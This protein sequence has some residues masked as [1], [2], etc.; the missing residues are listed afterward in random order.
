MKK[1]DKLKIS[2]MTCAS[3]SS[4]IERKLN[5]IDSVMEANVNLAMESANIYYDENKININDLISEIEK[6]GFQ[7]EKLKKKSLNDNQRKDELKN[8]K[9]LLI[10]SSFLSF[11]LVLSM[12][13]MLFNK[14]FWYFT[15][16]YF[17]LIL[18]T[19]IQF[20]IGFR[21][22]KNAYHVLKSGSSNMDVL[23][24]LGTT[25]AYL[26]SV[27]NLFFAKGSHEEI[28]FESAAIII[29][30][31]LLGKYLEA[32]AKNKTSDAIRKLMELKAKTAIVLQNGLEIEIPIEKVLVGDT[33]IVKPGQTIPVDGI[34]LNGNS[35]VDESMITGESV[36]VEKKESDEVIGATINKFGT[37]Q[38][39]AKKIG[40]DT[41][42]SQI[43]KMVEEAQGSKAPIQKLA[44]RVAGIFVPV[45]VIIAIITFTLWYIIS[46][47]LN[48]AVVNMV[49][50]LVIA[51]PCA[52]GLATPTAIMVGTGKGAENGILIKGGEHLEK[53][54]MLDTI[55]FDKTG[56]ITKG[57]PEVV[58]IIPFDNMS[59]TD[60]LTY[61]ASIEKYSEHPI[62]SA[63]YKKGKQ[64]N[65]DLYTIDNFSAIPGKGIS[66]NIS[67]KNIFVG[68]K[69]LLKEEGINIKEHENLIHKL[70]KEGKTVIFMAL[71]NSLK[72]IIT[73]ADTV[74]ESSKNGIC[75]LKDMGIDIYMLTGDN[76]NT[77]QFIGKQVGID[78]IIAEVLPENKKDVIE[79][80]K[81]EGKIVGMVG[82]GINDA[83][84]LTIADIG[85]S[86]GTGTDIAIEASDITL[87]KGD[88]KGVADSIF[89]SK[90]TMKKIKQNLFWAFIYN[91]VGIPFAAFGFLSPI[92]AG[93]AMAFSSVSVVTNS[94]S[95]KKIKL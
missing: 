74:K 4:R 67:N 7:A 78:N 8:L 26:F 93:S 61:T 1:N 25:S 55:V 83:P 81:K 89:L 13:L 40:K 71:D 72:G 43:I 90:K 41:V 52:L 91:T 6:L 9:T 37:F 54:F 76:K 33:V 47:D 63:I 58:E 59:E 3:C 84:A 16:P 80:L 75:K 82:D 95:L 68:T 18:T 77:A 86:I 73:V 19:P 27:Y 30:L 2:G 70:E 24:S 66:G 50:V 20:G 23:I 85:I 10:I 28:Y 22:Y 46:K 48:N 11:P 45:V 31:I 64:L 53:V 35:T 88:L 17:Q 51:C 38:I 42:L 65:K 62:G 94:L 60:I 44:D 79:K 5:K 92:I 36:P 29:T 39:T 15:S 49:S 12:L 87:I 32:I 34:V 14:E 56:T 69:N 21:F 57:E